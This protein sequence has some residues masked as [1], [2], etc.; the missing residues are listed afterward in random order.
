MRSRP[1]FSFCNME[2]YF[3][4]LQLLHISIHGKHAS[5]MDYHV[6]AGKQVSTAPCEEVAMTPGADMWVFEASFGVT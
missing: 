4:T 1:S 5:E 6:T 2:D 3:V